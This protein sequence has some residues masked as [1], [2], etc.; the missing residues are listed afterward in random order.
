MKKESAVDDRVMGKLFGFAPCCVDYYCANKGT[1]AIR[2]AKGFGG[3]RLC[4]VCAKLP[5]EDVIMGI[6][7]RRIC[8]TLFPDMPGMEHFNQ[9]VNDP[10]WT[11]GEREWL[12]ANQRRYT[13]EPDP[14]I[15]R[16]NKLHRDMAKLEADYAESVAR[17]PERKPFL[18]AV[19]EVAKDRLVVEFMDANYHYLRGRLLEQAKNGAIPIPR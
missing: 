12:V 5:E 4:P 16:V 17:E 10:R 11:E 8:P 14:G 3:M 6:H 19:H 2:L 9:I 15:E 7:Q 18:H 13:P 1:Q